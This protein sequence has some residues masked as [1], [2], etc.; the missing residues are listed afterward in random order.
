VWPIAWKQ[1]L[2]EEG[3]ELEEGSPVVTDPGYLEDRGNGSRQRAR[4]LRSV[5]GANGL[6]EADEVLLLLHLELGDH[7]RVNQNQLGRLRGF[8]V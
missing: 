6:E 2:G 3:G 7:S 1:R 5:A 4:H 8:R